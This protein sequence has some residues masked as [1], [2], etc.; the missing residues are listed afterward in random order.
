LLL[1]RFPVDRCIQ[2]IKSHGQP[3]YLGHLAQLAAQ[4]FRDQPRPDCLVPIPMHWLS[5][6]RRGFNQS[7]LLAERL[8]TLLKIPVKTA[9]LNKAQSTAQQHNLSKRA[10]QRNLKGVFRCS[11]AVPAHI[12]LIDDV[13][14]TGAT[15]NEAARTLKHHGAVRVDAWVL[16]RTP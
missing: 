11:R 3:G 7:L 4:H 9:L 2:L 6:Q 10:R 5:Q 13:M 12:V 1:Y 14:T 16:A 15:L 8:G